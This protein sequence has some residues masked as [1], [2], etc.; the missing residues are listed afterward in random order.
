MVIFIY[1]IT[2]ASHS[3]TVPHNRLR[4]CVIKYN[5]SS[6]DASIVMLL[7]H[8]QLLGVPPSLIGETLDLDYQIRVSE[9]IYN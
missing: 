6:S 3:K 7:L 2:T 4:M 8:I 1:K 5:F 9:W